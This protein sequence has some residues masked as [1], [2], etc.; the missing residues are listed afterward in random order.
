MQKSVKKIKI[1][2]G[3][4]GKLTP[5]I[6]LLKFL[7]KLTYKEKFLAGKMRKHEKAVTKGKCAKN[8]ETR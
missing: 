2:G 6:A 8:H 1:S 5:V 4:F 3:F 7:V